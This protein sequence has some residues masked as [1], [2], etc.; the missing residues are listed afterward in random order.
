MF[1][2]CVARFVGR[3]NPAAAYPVSVASYSILNDRIKIYLLSM[4]PVT[5]TVK[6]KH[7]RGNDHRSFVLLVAGKWE[8]VRWSNVS[9]YQNV[10]ID[11]VSTSRNSVKY[12]KPS[13]NK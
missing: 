4:T 1:C 12:F 13:L 3:I 9:S 2:E 6:Q 10:N 7:F 8:L 11:N 5:R